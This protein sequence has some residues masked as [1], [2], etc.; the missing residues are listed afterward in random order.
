MGTSSQHELTFSAAT[1]GVFSTAIRPHRT[2]VFRLQQMAPAVVLEVVPLLSGSVGVDKE[3]DIGSSVILDTWREFGH[4]RGSTPFGI[5][6]RYC[7]LQFIRWG[8]FDALVEQ[9][10]S[11]R[12]LRKPSSKCHLIALVHAQQNPPLRRHLNQRF[13]SSDRSRR[14]RPSATAH[15]A[16][17][18]ARRRHLSHPRKART[19]QSH[20]PEVHPPTR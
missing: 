2:L 5:S 4:G 19:R 6:M 11:D 18:A 9:R 13:P 16:C 10:G 15:G 12:R 20:A 1:H 3:H 7:P 14:H 8:R 17:G